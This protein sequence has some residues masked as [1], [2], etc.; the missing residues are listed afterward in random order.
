MPDTKTKEAKRSRTA[1]TPARMK[2][3]AGHR[4][5][6]VP[7]I[8]TEKNVDEL[9]EKLVKLPKDSPEYDRLADAC[10]AT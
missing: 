3:A 2:R 10:T 9:W 7:I 1:P 5:A 8:V 4:T 6:P